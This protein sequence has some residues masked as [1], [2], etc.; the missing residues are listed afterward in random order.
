L[1]AQESLENFGE[2]LGVAADWM[3][4]RLQDAQEGFSNL[5]EVI[6]IDFLDVL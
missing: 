5:L 1:G 3:M 4:A 2:A 6:G